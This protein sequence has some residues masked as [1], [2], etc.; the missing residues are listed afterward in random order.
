MSFKEKIAWISVITT[1]LVRGGY[2]GFM[3]RDRREAVRPS[4]SRRLH[5]R[6]D[7]PGRS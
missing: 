1:A 3:L 7:R 6:S 4:L 5:R 2:F